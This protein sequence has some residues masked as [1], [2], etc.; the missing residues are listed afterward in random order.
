MAMP[1]YK[2]VFRVNGSRSETVVSANSSTAARKLIEAQ[3]AGQKVS[4]ISVTR[5]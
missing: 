2:V 5:V 1:Q 3:Y 4:I